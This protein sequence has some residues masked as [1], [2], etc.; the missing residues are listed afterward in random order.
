MP[1]EILTKI[2]R[3]NTLYPDD[4]GDVSQPV[5]QILAALARRQRLAVGWVPFRPDDWE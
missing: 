5:R 4:T 1:S 3:R 2:D